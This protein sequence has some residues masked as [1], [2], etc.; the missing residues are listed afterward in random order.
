MVYSTKTNE[1]SRTWCKVNWI[2]SIIPIINGLFSSTLIP[3]HKSQPFHCFVTVHI[4]W[5]MVTFYWW[6]Q[7]RGEIPLKVQPKRIAFIPHFYSFSWSYLF[8]NCTTCSEKLARQTRPA[9]SHCSRGELIKRNREQKNE[10]KKYSE[11]LILRWSCQKTEVIVLTR[12]LSTKEVRL[13]VTDECEKKASGAIN[14]RQDLRRRT[15]PVDGPA[16]DHPPWVKK[17]R[18]KNL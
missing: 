11:W 15:M 13:I 5:K 12:R 4:P 9:F 16:T 17:R 1:R 3:L 7:H 2:S 10:D 8:D 14:L 6:R 18:G